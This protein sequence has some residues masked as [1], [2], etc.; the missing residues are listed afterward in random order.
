MNECYKFDERNFKDSIFK[1]IDVTYIVHLENNGRLTHIE[2]QLQK[3]HPT[4]KIYIL[5]N[6]GY[7][8]CKKKDYIDTSVKDLIDAFYTIFIHARE[9]KYNNILILE[10]DF[11]FDEK[12][13]ENN[14][15][16]EKIDE[17]IENNKETI[18]LYYL[19]SIT[20]MQT[21]FNEY[22]NRLILSTGT[23]ACI[24]S[25]K[26]R[27]YILDNIE[28]KSV[29]DWDVFLNTNFI[30]RFKYFIPLCY[31]T[32]PDTEN[33]KHWH[34]GSYL[35]YIIVFIQRSLFKYLNLS[36]DVEPGFSVF[37]VESRFIFWIFI[38]IILYIILF[39]VRNN[40]YSIQ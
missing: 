12:I 10:D 40:L 35:L 32:F 8:Q 26:T 14:N 30:N 22:N 3:Y 34:R 13:N 31:Q 11:I 19:G 36:N 20:W 1:N 28:Q 33:S 29:C 9:K 6:K 24:Y 39:F 18:F 5:F 4:K 16:S 37:E 2:S 7:K 15:H 25:K 21:Y 27:E 38:I 17:F 23:H